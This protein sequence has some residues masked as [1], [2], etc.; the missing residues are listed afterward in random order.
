MKI[1]K[2]QLRRIIKEEKA[3][4]L[5]EEIGMSDEDTI[6]EV[7]HKHFAMAEEEIISMGIPMDKMGMLDHY[8]K[9]S[10]NSYR[11]V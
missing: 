4:I 7:F 1:T 2:R 3:K 5:T 11:G 10:I 9:M 6:Q 8:I